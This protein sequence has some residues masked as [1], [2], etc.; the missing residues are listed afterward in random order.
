M[1]NHGSAR[2]PF[3]A[4]KR[5]QQSII[6]SIMAARIPSVVVYRNVESTR[7]RDASKV[8]TI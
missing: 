1:K 3:A 7:R 6:L 8:N 5:P 2:R 4:S